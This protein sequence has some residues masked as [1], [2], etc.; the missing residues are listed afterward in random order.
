MCLRGYNSTGVVTPYQY[1]SSL[2]SIPSTRDPTG[3]HGGLLAPSTL[4][5]TAQFQAVQSGHARDQLR[6]IRDV[7]GIISARNAISRKTWRD[8]VHTSQ[9]MLGGWK[10]D[11][12]VSQII[13]S[14]QGRAVNKHKLHLLSSI[15]GAGRWF[16]S[17]IEKILGVNK[18]IAIRL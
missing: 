9:S 10:H 15:Y 4:A 6:N 7:P 17:I 1:V 8:T 18:S 11:I 12:W 16:T 14:A 5:S 2:K 13:P 3:D